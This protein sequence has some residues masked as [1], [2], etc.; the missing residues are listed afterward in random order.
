[1]VPLNITSDLILYKID[2]SHCKLSAG[3]SIAPGMEIG[4]DID[5]GSIIIADVR[6]HV[7]AVHFS[8]GDHAMIVLVYVEK[9]LLLSY[10]V[11]S[12]FRGLI[13]I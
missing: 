1:M 3:D 8:G 2:A 5:T 12:A 13:R 10:H 11:G 9:E 6:G 4:K 7:H